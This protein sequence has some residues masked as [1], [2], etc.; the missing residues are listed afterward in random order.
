MG[1]AGRNELTSSRA[2]DP[3]LVAGVI[4]NAAKSRGHVRRGLA[5]FAGRVGMFFAF[6]LSAYWW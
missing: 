4:A 6:G 2:R 5:T 3:S 1:K